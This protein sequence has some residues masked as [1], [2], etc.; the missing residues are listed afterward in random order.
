MK[1]DFSGWFDNLEK[2]KCSSILSA[3]GVDP[4]V[5]LH[6]RNSADYCLPTLDHMAPNYGILD[7]SD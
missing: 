4:A 6:L 1:N 3:C 5:A 7:F 2:K